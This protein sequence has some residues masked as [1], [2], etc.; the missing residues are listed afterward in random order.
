[1][2][3]AE[4]KS[5]CYLSYK[6]GNV[7]MYTMQSF[8]THFTLSANHADKQVTSHFR[9]KEQHAFVHNVAE[10]AF[11]WDRCRRY[12]EYSLYKTS[13]NMKTRWLFSFHQ[14]SGFS[15]SGTVASQVSSPCM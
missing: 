12:A 1:M 4:L 14:V 2:K 3:T 8:S 15:V 10:Q 6:R 9:A 13:K 7:C 11:A 5:T